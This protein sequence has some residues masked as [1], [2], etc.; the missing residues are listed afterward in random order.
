LFRNH[1]N[2][3]NQLLYLNN[4]SGIILLLQIVTQA[5]C[6]MDFRFAKLQHE[7]II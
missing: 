4:Y 1:D 6:L 5:Q 2:I 3:I 7:I